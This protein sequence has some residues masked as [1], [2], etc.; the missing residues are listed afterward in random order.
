MQDGLGLKVFITTDSTGFELSQGARINYSEELF[1]G[2]IN[3]RPHTVLFDHGI[4]DYHLQVESHPRF[5]KLF[6]R[7]TGDPIPFDLFGAAFWLLS[8]Y[9]EYLPYKADVQNRFHYRSA[10]AYQYDFLHFPLVNHWLEELRKIMEAIFPQLEFRKREYNFVSSIDVDNAY[11]YKFKGFVRTLAGMLTDKSLSVIKDRI[12]IILGRRA[13]P[14]DCYDYLIRTHKTHEVWAICFFLLGDY[15]PNDKNHSA[16]DLRFQKL[17]KHVADYAVVGIHPS[18]GSSHSL[19]QLKTEVSRLSNIVHRTI[20]RS[21]Q[22]FAMLKFPQTYQDLL[23]AGITNDYTMGYTNRNGFRAS[24]C[25]PYRWYNLDL[26]AVSSLNIHSFCVTDNA[27]LTASQT[28]NTPLVE[29]AKPYIDEVRRYG[30][31][32]VSI[33]H[34]DNFD[35]RMRKV[36]PEFLALAKK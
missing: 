21:R 9:E 28:A 20:I 30:G 34:N 23:Q 18:Y 22:H 16:A 27:L 35:E 2:V 29:L 24:Y 5:R 14:F 25:Y 31:E 7:N 6:F 10:V 36:Y 32:M 3:V 33:F 8:R 1:E 13:D 4:R 15:G 17:I 11:K 19:R 26:E 12:S